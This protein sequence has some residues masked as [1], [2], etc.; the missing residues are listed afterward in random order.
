LLDKGFLEFFGAT[1]VITLL[2]KLAAHG[3]S[4]QTG[5]IYNYLSIMFLSIFCLFIYFEY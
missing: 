1:G 4:V 2:N 3:I 5:L